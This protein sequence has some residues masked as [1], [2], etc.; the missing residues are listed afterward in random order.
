MGSYFSWLLH[1]QNTKPE[2]NKEQVI[3]CSTCKEIAKYYIIKVGYKDHT[4][5]YCSYSCY[6]YR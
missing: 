1:W 4:K 2:V 6:N 3:Y 5:Y